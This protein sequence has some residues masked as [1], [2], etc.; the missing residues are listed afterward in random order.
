MAEKD[1]INIL[2]LSNELLDMISDRVQDKS[3]VLRLRLVNRRL[4]KAATRTIQ[5][6]AVNIYLE[7]RYS[8]IERFKQI[9][10]CPVWTGRIYNICVIVPRQSGPTLSEIQNSEQMA[11]AIARHGPLVCEEALRRFALYRA[12]YAEIAETN[13][14]QKALLYGVETLRNLDG[15]TWALSPSCEEPPPRRRDVNLIELNRDHRWHYYLKPKATSASEAVEEV[16][17]TLMWDMHLDVPAIDW[18]KLFAVLLKHA[19]LH[20]AARLRVN[21]EPFPA[22]E[23]GE[24]MATYADAHSTDMSHALSHIDRV[25]L[26]TALVDEAEWLPLTSDAASGLRR[27]FRS[28]T[29]L[30]LLNVSGYDHDHLHSMLAVLFRDESLTFPKLEQLGIWGMLSFI[31]PEHEALEIFRPSNFHST[32][33]LISFL[34]RHGRS[35][36]DLWLCNAIGYDLAAGQPSINALKALLDT[37]KKECLHLEAVSVCDSMTYMY[38]LDPLTGQYQQRS[39]DWEREHGK[40]TELARLG[41]ELGARVWETVMESRSQEFGDEDGMKKFHTFE[42]QFGWKLLRPELG[43]CDCQ[44]CCEGDNAPCAEPVWYDAV[45]GDEEWV[46]AEAQIS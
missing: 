33:Q 46:D 3:D 11:L 14:L 13:E 34:H 27:F 8:S 37:I 40:S 29:N 26:S 22:N 43:D 10:N 5:M 2:S 9:C 44:S 17:N 25:H 45:E 18:D 21:L 41:H 4:A 12:E 16:W 1:A 39:L 36:K 20:P 31:Y 15:I 7:P 19:D 35:L 32:P 42:Y 24:F 6:R 28:L 30:K 38:V 23:F